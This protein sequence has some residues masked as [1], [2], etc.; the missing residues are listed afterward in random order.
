LPIQWK[1]KKTMFT[2]FDVADMV[3]VLGQKFPD[4]EAPYLI[5][6]FIYFITSDDCNSR[7]APIAQNF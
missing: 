7:R 2:I 4:C 5:S 1:I 3:P 6:D